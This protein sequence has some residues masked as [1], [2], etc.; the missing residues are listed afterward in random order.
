MKCTR[1]YEQ[2]ISNGSV[3]TF[4]ISWIEN[5]ILTV[6]KLYI[7]E[8]LNE[9]YRQVRDKLNFDHLNSEKQRDRCPTRGRTRGTTLKSKHRSNVVKN[10][11]KYQTHEGYSFV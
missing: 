2:F 4:T 7:A 1:S 5:N 10:A 11:L 9:M 8:L 6:Y 3:T